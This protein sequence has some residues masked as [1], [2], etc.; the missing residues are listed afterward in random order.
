MITM[1][2]AN[3]AQFMCDR[4]K[5]NDEARTTSAAAANFRSHNG[6]AKNNC[7]YRLR[8]RARSGR[9][10]VSS[11]SSKTSSIVAREAATDGEESGVRARSIPFAETG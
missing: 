1:C 9:N 7:I 4:A 5:R 3:T 10:A 11:K 2:A 8:A 6:G